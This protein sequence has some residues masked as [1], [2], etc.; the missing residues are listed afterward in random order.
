MNKHFT[1]L[2]LLVEIKTIPQRKKKSKKKIN[3]FLSFFF[4]FSLGI[5]ETNEKKAN[6]KLIHFL[7][8]LNILKNHYVFFASVIRKLT[9]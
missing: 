8:S 9:Y 5:E 4:T 1:L 2:A 7:H 3:V 6:Y